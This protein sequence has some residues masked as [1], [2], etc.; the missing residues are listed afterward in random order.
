MRPG[1]RETRLAWALSAPA[2]LT[3]GVFLAYPIAAAVLASLHHDTPFAE[4][5]F[6]GLDN[7]GELLE[8]DLLRE[9]L[10][11]TFLFVG[12]S[13]TLEVFSGLA[14]AL[15][16]H[17]SFRGR[18]L[19]RAAVL[20]PWAVPTVVTAVMWKYMASDQ[21]GLL[22]LLLHGNEIANYDAFLAHQGSA[23]LILVLADVWK[24]TS[25]AALLLLA[26]LQAI[27]DELHEAARIDGAWAWR[28]FWHVTLPLLRPAILLAVLFRTIDAFRVFDLVYVMTRGAPA[29]S[30]NVLSFHGYETMFP[31]QLFGYGSAVSV[32]V[33]LITATLAVLAVRA[34]G[35]KGLA[36]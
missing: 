20:V 17:E 11:F 14:I 25:F 19:L 21:Y 35:T 4:R 31:E 6:A 33:F 8:D 23:R 18:G 9:S 15:V 30:T 27:P 29:G 12:T 22:N 24:T 16:L 5:R 34:I 36:R 26:G 13:V 2:L 1:G 3:I 10:V 32:L 28:R 7:Y